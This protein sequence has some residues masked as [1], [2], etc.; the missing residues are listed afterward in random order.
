M[1]PED[2]NLTLNYRFRFADNVF[3]NIEVLKWRKSVRVDVNE[4]IKFAASNQFKSVKIFAECIEQ[5]IVHEY[6]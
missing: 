2:R 6:N 1:T 3:P 4:A 5:R